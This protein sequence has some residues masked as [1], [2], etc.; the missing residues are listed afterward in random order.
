MNLISYKNCVFP[1]HTEGTS[2]SY[3]KPDW[4]VRMEELKEQMQGIVDKSQNR[5]SAASFWLHGNNR[6]LPQVRS[7]HD[8]DTFSG[9][10]QSLSVQNQIQR[11]SL[12]KGLIRG[13]CVSHVVPKVSSTHP[14][15]YV[16]TASNKNVSNS[17]NTSMSVDSLEQTSDVFCMNKDIILDSQSD[18]G[19]QVE[20]ECQ[21]ESHCE[22]LAQ[23]EVGS[24]L[25]F[26]DMSMGSDSVFIS[27]SETVSEV[28]SRRPSSYNLNPIYLTEDHQTLDIA[29]PNL[30][31]P[32][33]KHVHFKFD[34]DTSTTVS[35]D[36]RSSDSPNFAKAVLSN[37][38]SSHRN[39]ISQVIEA[40]SSLAQADITTEI[41]MTIEQNKKTKSQKTDKIEDNTKLIRTETLP[42]IQITVAPEEY[43]EN[44]TETSITPKLAET[45]LDNS[46]EDS[47]NINKD[48]TTVDEIDTNIISDKPKSRSTV[49]STLEI[50]LEPVQDDKNEICKENSLSKISVEQY[51]NVD[52]G[53]KSHCGNKSKVTEINENIPIDQKPQLSQYRVGFDQIVNSAIKDISLECEN[54]SKINNCQN[55]KKSIGSTSNSIALNYKKHS[56]P[57]RLPILMRE[58]SSESIRESRFSKIPRSKES[59]PSS[60]PIAN[61]KFNPSRQDSLSKIPRGV[62]SREA[63]SDSLLEFKK[64]SERNVSSEPTT[65]LSTPQLIRKTFNDFHESSKIPMPIYHYSSTEDLEDFSPQTSPRSGRNKQSKHRNRSIRAVSVDRAIYII[66]H[67]SP[68]TSKFSKKTQ[69]SLPTTPRVPSPSLNKSGIRSNTSSQSIPSTPKRKLSPTS[70]P[71]KIQSPVISSGF[72]SFNSSKVISEKNI[73]MNDESSKTG[74]RPKI[75][76]KTFS[77]RLKEVATHSFLEKRTNEKTR[78]DKNNLDST[79]RRSKG[80]LHRADS[81]EE[82]LLL[83]SV[84]MD[85]HKQL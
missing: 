85:G 19:S 26:G 67:Q 21:S 7:D 29:K 57:S 16:S 61:R 14:V 56:P 64:S 30:L 76:E 15:I 58:S 5:K 17:L 18:N 79:R 48:E 37:Y 20:A 3:R 71:K 43:G 49:T 63:S 38:L 42:I 27:E 28:T 65:P 12:D 44:S 69:S 84:C 70:T 45:I 22:H 47:R 52:L 34:G 50:K 25:S 36:E 41:E 78:K 68:K 40:L 72:K 54:K 6:S 62:I 4:V 35:E 2:K 59:T 55:I 32:N 33:T 51:K 73:N 23:L 80:K 39:S 24:T 74:A 10:Q 77:K 13:A 66:Q 46:P 8:N 75:G 81:L 1:E 9:Q 31:S 53:D 83:E 60:T 82:F 11:K